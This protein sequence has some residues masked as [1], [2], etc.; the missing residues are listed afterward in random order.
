MLTAA[1]LQTLTYRNVTISDHAT[2]PDGQILEISN[3]YYVVQNTIFPTGGYR[4]QVRLYSRGNELFLYDVQSGT[5]VRLLPADIIKSHIQEFNGFAHGKRFELRNGETWEQTD[6]L[7][8]PC[9]PGG[10]VWIKD[11]R[12]MRVGNWDFNVAV[13]RNRP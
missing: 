9:S 11:Q 6:T 3:R 4:Q 1:E 7:N 2:F 8:S 10:K 13:K 12:V 5:C